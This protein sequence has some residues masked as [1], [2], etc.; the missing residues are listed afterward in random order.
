MQSPNPSTI[1]HLAIPTHDLNDAASFYEGTLGCQIARRYADRITMN[2]YGAQVV[3]HLAPDDIA[4]EIR[5]YP[6][7]FGVTFNDALEFDS[8]CQRLEGAGVD[9][10]EPPFVRWQGRIDEHRSVLLADPSN[11]VLEFKNYTHSSQRF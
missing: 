3:C 2:F 11:N 5:V 6:R 4:N 1:F 10:L 7:H 8:L 9:F